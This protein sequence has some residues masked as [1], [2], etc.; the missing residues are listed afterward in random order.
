MDGQ[1]LSELNLASYYPYLSYTPQEPPV[2]D[3]S[4]R[5]NLVFDESVPDEALW[6]ALDAVELTAFAQRLPLGLET[7][8]GERGVLLSGGERQRLALARLFFQPSA[9]IFILDEATS[10]MD[11][12]TE[13][14]VLRRLLS[15]LS[16][17]TVILIAHR[18]A[19]LRAADVIY[20]LREGRIQSQG[21]YD[22]LSQ[23]SPYFQAL[24]ATQ[25][26]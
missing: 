7:P 5:E 22:G 15:H 16:G 18:L 1:P 10:A 9:R 3:G 19:T 24:L 8:I 26:T 13:D 11:N 6:A 25:R 12:L 2:F 21:T 20:L 17:R 23:Q 4:L 14:A